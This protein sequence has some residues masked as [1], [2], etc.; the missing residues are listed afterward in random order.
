MTAP[1]DRPRTFFP[2][3]LELLEVGQL[4]PCDIWLKHGDA[5][6]VLYRASRLPFEAEHKRRL[7][8]SGVQ[9]VWIS[10]GDA[11]SWN[12]HLARQLRTRVRDPS[13]PL[14]ERMRIMVHS[15]RDLMRTIVENPR[16]P[17]VKDQVDA[18]SE[19]IAELI[20][21]PEALAA[22]V[23]LM[24]HDYYTYTHS[25]HVAIYATSLA[26]DIGISDTDDLRSIGRG[27]LMHDCGKCGLPASL[28]NKAG[29]LTREEWE[30]I[31]THPVRGVEV[32]TESGWTDSLAIEICQAHHERLDGSGY[33]QGRTAPS[34]PPEVRIVSI[35]DAF[36]AMTTDR[37]YQKART[38]AE[39]LR[40]LHV[41]G[42]QKYDQK[43]LQ[44]F[45]RLMLDR[46][47]ASVR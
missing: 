8:E 27:A 13:I 16:A 1:S 37:S 43:L 29:T 20:D 33:P 40:V 23:R 3:S 38:G 11:E 10:F 7:I 4:L 46:E 12:D 18:V 25:L 15:A 44:R 24:E 35:S 22:A 17:G 2:V 36:D 26:R 5:E 45:V 28:L 41:E 30:L 9:S 34:I 14:P 47:R 21:G 6:P 42:A 19:S 39:A 31:K 32:L